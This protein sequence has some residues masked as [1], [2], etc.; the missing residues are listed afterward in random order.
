MKKFRKNIAKIPAL[1]ILLVLC[2][3]IAG[4]CSDDSGGTAGTPVSP[5]QPGADTGD[6][7]H[8]QTAQ[9]WGLPPGLPI[10]D[11]GGREITLALTGWHHYDPLVI[12]DINVEELT[13]EGLNDAAFNRNIFIEQTFNCT[14]NTISFPDGVGGEA[15]NR[16]RNQVRAGDDALD[17]VFFRAIGVLPALTEGLLHDFSSIPYVNINNPWW[18]T[19]SINAMSIGG[20]VFSAI[21]DYTMT[22]LS[23]V[24]LTY[25]NKELIADYGL[26]DPHQLVRE[27]RW[28]L[29][30]MYEMGR[31]VAADLNGD[32]IMDTNDRFG[33]IHINNVGVALLNGFG[34]RLIDIGPDG[35][36][37]ISVGRPSAIERF[38][39]IAEILDN[40][41]VFLNAHRRTPQAN[42]YEAGMFV[43]GQALFSLGGVYYAPEMREMEQMFGLAPYP[44]FD[45]NQTEWFN[46]IHSAAIPLMTVPITTVNLDEI[47]VFMEAFTYQGYSNIRPEFYEVMLQRKV[48]RDDESEA[49]LDFIFNNIF[50]DIGEAYNFGGIYGQIYTMAVTNN[51]NIVSWLDRNTAR[52]NREIEAFI[53]AVLGY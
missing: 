48:A 30:K 1:C 5:N 49:M 8:E 9:V 38:F 41:D 12:H 20:R 10:V 40:H 26:D 36:P 19:S 14:I 18:D 13:G 53:D 27:G 33:F 22:V 42:R 2:V 11:M 23:C 6:D 32:G 25:F 15:M 17:I 34:E 37:Y 3:S 51:T 52:I 16:V 45:E 35:L 4:S 50:F 44:K 28:T 24:W 21:G 43:W 7:T 46:P 31:A 29:R 39:H 47:G